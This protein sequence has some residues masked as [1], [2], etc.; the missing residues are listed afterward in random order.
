MRQ[1]PL[2]AVIPTPIFQSTHLLR[3]ATQPH[4]SCG[5][6]VS[7]SIHAPL[8]RCDLSSPSVHQIFLYISIHAPLAR[9]D[10]QSYKFLVFAKLFQS[11]HLLRGAT[12][13]RNTDFRMPGYFNP[14]TSCEVRLPTSL[15]KFKDKIFQSTHLLRG[16]TT[17]KPSYPPT[18]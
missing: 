3:G 12:F 16:A 4:E 7:I 18:I 5:Q 11:T 6:A 2:S 17:I 13:S 15:W 10:V 8:A 9:C 1:C 14:R